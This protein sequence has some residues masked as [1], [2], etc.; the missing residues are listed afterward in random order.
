MMHFVGGLAALAL[1]AGVAVAKPPT[2]AVQAVNIEDLDLTLPAD[3]AV[4]EARVARMAVRACDPDGLLDWRTR[5][6]E[7]FQRCVAHAVSA[8][9]QRTLATARPAASADAGAL[10]R[11]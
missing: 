6:R 7:A 11:E 1:L 2:P 5:D 8:T 4:F 9:L 10:A 3:T